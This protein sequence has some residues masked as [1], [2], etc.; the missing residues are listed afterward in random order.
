[1]AVEFL[2]QRS[3]AVS[4]PVVESRLAVFSADGS[5]SGPAAAWNEDG[6]LNSP[7]RPAAPGS[8]ITFYATGAPLE[9]TTEASTIRS[10]APLLKTPVGVIFSGPYPEGGW[11]WDEQPMTSF[12]ALYAGGVPGASSGLI[13]IRIQLPQ[14]GW[15]FHPDIW[16]PQLTTGKGYLASSLTPIYVADR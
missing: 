14:T 1:V 6:S 8:V 12:A 5:G 4:L 7:D 9:N 13:Q 15:S 10:P 3:R 11:L 16:I 2:G